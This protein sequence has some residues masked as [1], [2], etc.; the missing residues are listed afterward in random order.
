MINNI[1]VGLDQNNAFPVLRVVH[2]PLYGLFNVVRD[3]FR[4]PGGRTIVIVA[5]LLT[6][7]KVLFFYLPVASGRERIN[8]IVARQKKK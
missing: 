2:R 5:L 8:I 7:R 6:E 3:G 4:C 1:T